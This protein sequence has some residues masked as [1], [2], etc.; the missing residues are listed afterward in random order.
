MSPVPPLALGGGVEPVAF[1]V[2]PP[3]KGTD[4]I[5]QFVFDASQGTL[6]QNTPNVIASI[7]VAGPRHLVFHPT[8]AFAFAINEK[9]DTIVYR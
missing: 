5:A 9:D 8:A 2:P 7:E 4:T 6:T 3:N 1:D